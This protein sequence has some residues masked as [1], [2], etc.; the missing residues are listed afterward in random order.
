MKID[1]I[2]K[3]KYAIAYIFKR[4]EEKIK[5]IILNHFNDIDLN[6]FLWIPKVKETEIIK[7]NKIV[8]EKP[9]YD[10]YIFM[11]FENELDPR[12]E[13]LKDNC[14]N[15]IKF[16]KTETSK[17]LYFLNK[18]D[19]ELIFN[20]INNCHIDKY[21]KFVG[22]KFIIISGC[23]SGFYGKCISID[24]NKNL[25]KGTINMLGGDRPISIPLADISLV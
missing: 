10:N 21:V 8:I 14:S 25:V 18:D 5:Q 4:S 11:N 2:L 16:L 23:F 9:L 13:F 1:E 20:A 17:K 3:R 6:S 15:I 7:G 12:I 19:I 22:K 24:K